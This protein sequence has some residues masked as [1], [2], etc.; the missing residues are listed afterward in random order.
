MYHLCCKRQVSRKQK[1]VQCGCESSKEVCNL[2]VSQ[3]AGEVEDVS[4]VGFGISI[5]AGGFGQTELL[6]D[7]VKLER[8]QGKHF[9]SLQQL[10]TY[11]T[12]TDTHNSHTL[13]KIS[14][15]QFTGFLEA[16]LL[17]F[18]SCCF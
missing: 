7:G 10:L 4:Q 9:A 8:T 16:S 1:T 2:E 14:S 17:T 3:P 5:T 12:Q 13:R 11:S 6:G 18:H 15:Q